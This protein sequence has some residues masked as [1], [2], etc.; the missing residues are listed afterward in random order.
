MA[1]EI[2]GFLKDE[3]YSDSDV[4]GMLTPM[5]YY[6]G[7][8]SVLDPGPA[9]E[10]DPGLVGP[11]STRY[12]KG[13][14]MDILRE[15]QASRQ[16]PGPQVI[17][18]A[19]ARAPAGKKVKAVRVDTEGSYRAWRKRPAQMSLEDSPQHA[20]SIEALAEHEQRILMGDSVGAGDGFYRRDDGAGSF[21]MLSAGQSCVLCG[22]ASPGTSVCGGCRGSVVVGFGERGSAADIYDDDAP[23]LTDLLGDLDALETPMQQYDGGD[24]A[25]PLSFTQREAAQHVAAWQSGPDVYSSIRLTGWDGEPRILTST[26]RLDRATADVVGYAARA[27]VDSVSLIGVVGPLAR[28]LAAGGLIPRLAAASPVLLGLAR[29]LS[30]GPFIAVVGGS[31]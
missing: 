19:A 29:R 25:I 13:P 7:G 9:I 22:S 12:D 4:E 26:T 1:H 5:E 18:P 27:G 3:G 31:T 8:E 30:N 11:P 6:D 28:Q 16:R 14:S 17:V 21:A 24:S 2:V 23:T 20:P 10:M 15:A